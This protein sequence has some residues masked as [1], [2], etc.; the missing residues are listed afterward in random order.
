[1]LHFELKE[2]ARIAHRT[3]CIEGERDR[4]SQ[5]FTETK[6]PRAAGF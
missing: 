5:N 3:K 1:M 4:Q 2:G 6:R